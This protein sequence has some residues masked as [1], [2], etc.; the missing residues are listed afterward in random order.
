M[1]QIAAEKLT[2]IL[3]KHLAWL[4]GENGGERADLSEAD[5]SKANLSRANLDYSSGFS[6]RC[7]S[8][9]AVIDL[10]IGAQMAYHFCRMKSEDPDVIAAQRAIKDLANKFHRADECGKME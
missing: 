3:K 10:R 4:K 8:F 6:F 2:D 5:L 7:P 9:G 1:R